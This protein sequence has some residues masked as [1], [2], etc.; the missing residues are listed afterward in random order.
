MGPLPER[1]SRET[2]GEELGAKPER[3]S[4]AKGLNFILEAVGGD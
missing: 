1:S 4:W 3:D 2:P